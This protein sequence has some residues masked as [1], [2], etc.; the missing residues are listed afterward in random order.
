MS[1]YTRFTKLKHLIFKRREYIVLCIVTEPHGREISHVRFVLIKA[2]IYVSL[3]KF[4]MKNIDNYSTKQICNKNIFTDVP[5]DV[6]F[7]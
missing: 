7:V 3:T 2:K 4:I 1:R 6:D 5:T